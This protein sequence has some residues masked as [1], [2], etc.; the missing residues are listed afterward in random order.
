MLPHIE[1]KLWQAGSGEIFDEETWRSVVEALLD[2]FGGLLTADFERDPELRINPLASSFSR[3]IWSNAARVSPV[4]IGWSAVLAGSP[5]G[6]P[7]TDHSFVVTIDLFLFHESGQERLYTSDG[8]HF[9]QFVFDRRAEEQGKWR[10]L[11][12]QK[13][14]WGEWENLNSPQ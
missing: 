10:F 7:K 5:I 8:L 6:D 4:S 11:G 9:L 3:W 12:W 1:D 14:E 2:D 13:D